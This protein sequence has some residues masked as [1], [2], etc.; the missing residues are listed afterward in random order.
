MH[1]LGV[2][3]FLPQCGLCKFFPGGFV[4]QDG[5]LFSPHCELC[6]L[7]RFGVAVYCFGSHFGHD[8]AKNDL[9]VV[10]LNQAVNRLCDCVYAVV[11]LWTILGAGM[12]AWF[13]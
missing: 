2:C 8:R 4:V 9:G 10:F 13:A 11:G 12:G 1:R 5:L 3:I 6:L 7:I